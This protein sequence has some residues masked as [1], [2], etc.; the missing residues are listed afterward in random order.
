VFEKFAR[1]NEGKGKRIT[2]TGLGLYNSKVIIE[3]HQGKIWVESEEG[4]WAD[5]IFL[6][7]AFDLT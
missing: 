3:R 2:G 6:L 5:F 4:R 1:F 7:P